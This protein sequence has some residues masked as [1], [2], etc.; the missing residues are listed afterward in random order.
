[1]VMSPEGLGTKNDCADKGQ[2]QFTRPTK[3][4]GRHKGQEEMKAA[5][6]AVRS[7]QADFKLTFSKRVGGILASV[8]RRIQSLREELSRRKTCFV[9]LSK[10]Q[11]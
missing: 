1:V 3:R 5:I 6:S 4:D 8:D 2:H 11:Q 10:I 9:C 7:S